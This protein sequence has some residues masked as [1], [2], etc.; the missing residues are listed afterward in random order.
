MVDWMTG[1]MYN[2]IPYHII[3]HHR[4]PHYRIPYYRIP[5]YTLRYYPTY[6]TTSIISPVAPLLLQNFTLS[7]SKIIPLIHAF[8]T[9]IRECFT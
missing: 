9:F 4:I 6:H 3:P 2:I 7:L 1:W 5:Y 8:K